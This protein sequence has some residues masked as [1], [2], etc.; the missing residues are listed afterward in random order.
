MWTRRAIHDDYECVSEA[1]NGVASR[2]AEIRRGH[3]VVLSL[4]KGRLKP[5]TTISMYYGG[6]G[7]GFQVC[8]L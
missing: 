6:P 7:L 3:L 2:K 4:N 5:K 1:D 8:K